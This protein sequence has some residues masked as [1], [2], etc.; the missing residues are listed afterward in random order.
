MRLLSGVLL[1]V[2][3]TL[4]VRRGRAEPSY[5]NDA[6]TIGEHQYAVWGRLGLGSLSSVNGSGGVGA[7]IGLDYG[8]LHNVQLGGSI[9]MSYGGSFC[10]DRFAGS[11]LPSGCGTAISPSASVRARLGL[12]RSKSDLF[13]VGAELAMSVER[14]PDTVFLLGLQ[15]EAALIASVKVAPVGLVFVR[16]G[17]AWYHVTSPNNGSENL[18]YVAAGV[19]LLSGTWHPSA[20]VITTFASYDWNRSSD[21]RVLVRLG[22]SYAPAR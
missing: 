12:W 2:A 20:E 22:V 17:F 13:Q 9:G 15:P 7:Q 1:V 4:P 8:V 10:L 6:A 21:N 16:G 14:F 18:P 3:M 11:A 5:V 19:E